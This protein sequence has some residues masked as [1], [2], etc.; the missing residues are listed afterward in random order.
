MR[1]SAAIIIVL[2]VL[3]F[4]FFSKKKRDLL[5][6]YNAY[7]FLYILKIVLPTLIYSVSDNISI[8]DHFFLERSLADDEVFLKY[9]VLQSAGYFLILS[10]IRLCLK[11]FIS[12]TKQDVNV[13]SERSSYLKWGYSLYFL[14][15]IGF[16]LIISKVGGLMFFLSNLNLRTYMVRDLDFESYL[17]SLLNYAPLLLI[18]AKRWT[19]NSIKP[20]EIILIVLAG[21]MVG[22]GGRK[23]LMMIV[24]ECAVVYHYVVSPLEA[25][26]IFNAKM[27]SIIVVVFLFFTTYAKLRTPGAWEEFVNDPVEFYVGNNEGGLQNTIAGE[28]YVPFYVATVDYFDKHPKWCG[29]SFNGLLTAFIPSSF[30]PNKTPVDDG[31]YLYSIAHGANIQPP[32]PTHSL[33]GTSWPL[34]TFGAM[35]ANFGVIGVLCGMLLL[36]FFIGQCFKRM[37]K[38]QYQFRYVVFYTIV[39]FTFE[40]ST[41]RIVQVIIA[42]VLL[43]IIQFLINKR[44]A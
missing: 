20:L 36:G 26:K 23:A 32:V 12:S 40:I 42:F 21:L 34:E 9:C 25:K 7:T 44:Y 13:I 17:L 3:L 43:S 35:Y 4:F 28:S 41:L 2:P 37:V 29:S 38:S 10:G 39:L 31:M 15:F 14:G 33:D 22:L 6:P 18:Y 1:L 24:I 30:Y 16:L 27:I 5:N 8:A 19:K 11:N